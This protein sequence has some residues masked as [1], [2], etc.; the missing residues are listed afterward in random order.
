MVHR[1]RQLV[2][3]A[4]LGK[5]GMLWIKAKSWLGRESLYGIYGMKAQ[6]HNSPFN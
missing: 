1:G 6:G 2:S 5:I 3:M 4:I